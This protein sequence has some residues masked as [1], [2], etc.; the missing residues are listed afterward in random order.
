MGNSKQNG[1]NDGGTTS[2]SP[3][4]EKATG[5]KEKVDRKLQ[6]VPIGKL[7]SLADGWDVTLMFL[8]TVGACIRG[9]SIFVNIFLYGRIFKSFGQATDPTQIDYSN[10]RTFPDQLLQVAYIYSGLSVVFF[11]GGF[12]ELSCWL[13][14]GERQA[15]KLRRKYLE[16]VLT[17]EVGYFET[18][19]NTAEISNSLTESIAEIQAGMGEKVGHGIG[20][21]WAALSS[22]VLS[23]YNCWQLALLSLAI[24]PLVSAAGGIYQR[25]LFSVTSKSKEESTKAD[26]VVEETISQIRTVY[27]Y[28]GQTRAVKAFSDALKNCVKLGAQ[29]G[30][31]K[32]IGMGSMIGAVNLSWALLFYVGGIFI[33]KDIVKASHAI[34]TI[35]CV[36]YGGLI[37]AF[38]VP[39]IEALAKA[40]RLA[41]PIHEIL[42]R[43]PAVTDSEDAKPLNTNTTKGK[44]ELQNVYFVYPSR[45]D[46]TIFSGL[47]VHIPP[48]KS[49]AFV[50]ESGSGKSTIIS[51]LARFYDP[52]KGKVMLDGQ[53]YKRLNLQSLRS[54]IGLVGQEPALFATSIMENIRFGREG[55]TMEEC[56]EAAK[57]ANAHSF[58]KAL[59]DG[60]NTQVGERG[61]Q[62]SGGQKQRIAI[63]R[64]ML[65][66]PRVLLLD[67]ATS[68]LDADSE[69]I[70]QVALDSLMLG[71]TC[72]VVAHRLS[73]ISNV[74]I[75]AVLSAGKIV[76]QGSPSELLG[77]DEHGKFYKL[78][79]TQEMTGSSSFKVA[80]KSI[81]QNSELNSP[82]RIRRR[83][84]TYTMDSP[85]C[86]V[87]YFAERQYSPAVFEARRSY[88]TGSSD[89][90]SPEARETQSSKQR[91]TLYDLIFSKD[92]GEDGKSGKNKTVPTKTLNAFGIVKLISGFAKPEWKRVMIGWFGSISNGV[93]KPTLSLMV[94][95]SA[96]VFFKGNAMETALRQ[97]HAYCI[98]FMILACYAALTSTIEHSQLVLVGQIVTKR[99]RELL[100]TATLRNEVG[101]YDREENKSAMV[102]GRLAADG[103]SMNTAVSSM[104][105]SLINNLS[106]VLFAI[107]LGFWLEW[108]MTLVNSALIP[109]FILSSFL[110]YKVSK[111]FA[112]VTRASNEE[113][114]QIAT[115]SV[116][117]IRTVY[118]FTMEEHVFNRL[119]T[120]SG[121]LLKK[122][123]KRA[124]L[125]GIANGAISF[126]PILSYTV[127]IYYI[128]A[129]L[130]KQ[131]LIFEHAFSV[132]TI[133]SNTSINLSELVVLIPTLPAVIKSAQSI[134]DILHRKTEIDQDEHDNPK[135]DHLKG[136]IELKEVRFCYPSRP[137]V[138][139]LNKVN[140]QI[141]PG[142][143]VALVGESGS[144][145]SSIVALIERFYD[146]TGG[147]VLIDNI[148][149]KLFN[150]K[151]LRQRIGLVQ[152]EPMLFNL[153]IK[154]NILYGKEES[155]EA[156]MIEAAKAA[157][158]HTFI[159]SLPQGYNT[160][161]G[162][163]GTQL[164]GGQKQRVA[165]ARAILKN[166]SILLLDEATSALD[167]G[168]EQ[169]VQQALDQFLAMGSRTTV[170]VAHRLSTIKDANLIVVMSKGQI[171]EQG[172]QN[173]LLLKGG[174]YAR[175]LAN[176]TKQ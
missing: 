135:H 13:Y 113:V 139:V 121:G 159:S 132:L 25:S 1:A 39:D 104:A 80:R 105:S 157:N 169:I 63:A 131:T 20:F 24:V 60:Y 89:I 97:N 110:R 108:R 21:L 44:L 46:A 109:L 116:S 65:K 172:T 126:L 11:L 143:T 144:G 2:Q 176:H 150:L 90:C 3:G 128:Q 162:D 112:D 45:T 129:G 137:T 57:S 96:L 42:G 64:A 142:Q 102:T 161:V 125:A 75:I 119:A 99:I 66:S 10:Y 62:L 173:A 160:I 58:I 14:T 87:S 30:L 16:A 47:S 103:V 52:V 93:V 59:P 26:S 127:C 32:G 146:P 118:S 72:V 167:T 37:F 79:N 85:E 156:E 33:S 49:M 152:Q 23:F 88:A 94:V 117:N 7:Y 86:N 120:L 40:R 22:Q 82:I 4:V 18:H 19:G 175:R 84:G 17:Q 138:Q 170:V 124:L 74:D 55:A 168:S 107:G 148:D 154:E 78:K 83:L 36:V 12:V 76:E 153:T 136:F 147:Q 77:K 43:P 34:V 106:A 70:V 100:L 27:S 31:T 53:D 166:P 56:M 163:R 81:S 28:V 92:H 122:A 6:P 8:G 101:W 165:I 54:C 114:T 61:T 123:R 50:G 35:M 155:N 5:S 130:R 164:S 29:A 151:W 149:I 98:I 158:A 51:L 174:L 140:L 141:Q 111:G 71:R 41:Y 133:I 15:T 38:A 91:T 69:R 9:S 134:Y 145:K 95:S 48:G 68:A 73:T 67:E 171:V 115:E